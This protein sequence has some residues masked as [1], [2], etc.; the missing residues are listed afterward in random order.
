MA[1]EK[2]NDLVFD[3]FNLC[4][5]DTHPIDISLFKTKGEAYLME[6]SR[7]NTQFLM[8]KLFELP[9]VSEDDG[10]FIS[11]PKATVALPREKP[12]PKDKKPTKWEEF[13]KTKNMRLHNDQDKLV[14]DQVSDEFRPRFGMGRVNNELE[15]DWVVEVKESTPGGGGGQRPIPEGY[16][17]SDPFLEKQL[18]K[19]KS[20]KQQVK[21]QK[22]NM[23]KSLTST[24][25]PA[26]LNVA[27]LK[28]LDPKRARF[29]LK[30]DLRE[31]HSMAAVSTASM[32]KFDKKLAKEPRKNTVKPKNKLAGKAEMGDQTDEKQASLKL[33]DRVLKT[34]AQKKRAIKSNA[35]SVFQQ[36]AEQ[37]QRTNKKVH[38][39]NKN[40][41]RFTPVDKSIYR[42]KAGMP[43]TK[44]RGRN[45]ID[46]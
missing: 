23:G 3:L 34:N 25:I 43:V 17:A 30:N 16:T 41:A 4:A 5:H 44:K 38:L 39:M 6:H 20:Q 29:E 33:L 15:N 22:K 2:Q 13:A 35:T 36:Q 45:V 10:L 27:S 37:S 24:K 18:S 46:F 9:S 28:R 8:S 40:K 31:T 26:Q 21:N 32:G 12:V 11:L 7:Q 14:Y 19:K 1:S 42:S